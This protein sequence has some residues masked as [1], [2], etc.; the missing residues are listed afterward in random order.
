[1]AVIALLAGGFLQSCS[2]DDND[3]PGSAKDLV[4]LWEM[5][6]NIEREKVNGQII[7]DTDE[8]DNTLRYECREDGTFVEYEYYNGCWHRYDGYTYR[9]KG[10][11]IYVDWND[12]DP[13][14]VMNVT[15]LTSTTLVI[16]Q[17][18]KY[19]ENGDTYEFYVKQSFRKISD[20]D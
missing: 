13:E 3:G 8:D 18:G 20:F 17:S 2:D 14:G 4:G 5:T 19:K 10:G 11:K 9:Y 1:M 7:D 6:H 16:E 12:G 15:T